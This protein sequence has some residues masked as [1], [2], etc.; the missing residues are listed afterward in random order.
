MQ[1]FSIS[2]SRLISML[3]RKHVVPC[4]ACLAVFS[5]VGLAAS[6]A[7]LAGDLEDRV[8]A[9]ETSTARKGNRQ[10]SLK[11]SGLINHAVFGFDDG[12]ERNTYQT[13]NLYTGPRLRFEGEAIINADWQAG[14]KLYTNV[15]S[16]T[17]FTVT[18]N[19]DDDQIVPGGIFARRMVWYL[20]NKDAGR[21]SIGRTAPGVDNLIYGT[22]SNLFAPSSSDILLGSSLAFRNSATGALT[23]I[24]P[25]SL[26]S[27][28]FTLRRNVAL[29]TSPVING[30]T[31][32]A[33]Y[34]EDDTW[35]LSAYYANTHGDFNVKARAG[36]FAD[37]DN[38]N[39][40]GN[41]P[42]FDEVKGL[43][44]FLH[45]PSGVFVDA[46]HLHRS[47]EA[48]PGGPSPNDFDYTYGR[49]GWIAK[50][51]GL[52]RTVF[53]GEAARG[54]GGLEG[55]DSPGFTAA[56][57]LGQTRDITDTTLDRWG[58]GVSQN[59]DIASMEFYV[60]YHNLKLD[61]ETAAGALPTDPLR[62]IYSGAAFY[63]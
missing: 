48:K 7:V 41:A 10:M 32:R 12:A 57:G 44:S 39:G 62:I 56:G 18:Q 16:A 31:F 35:G 63:F 9:L 60:G 61:V 37:S 2:F 29:Y 5:V 43:V 3:H 46:L 45:K 47:F 8:M 40:S 58:V 4:G 42:D 26:T 51:N 25:L 6:D 17:S 15:F 24:T 55:V 23:G 54:V 14:F 30:V 19:D 53:F 11:V 34:G 52:G 27:F 1:V 50:L 28:L 59:I 13:S 22:T 49:L 33:G 36:Y 38:T 21:I 20:E